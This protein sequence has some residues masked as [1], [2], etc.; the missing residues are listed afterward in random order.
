MASAL[1][2]ANIQTYVKCVTTT[3]NRSQKTSSILRSCSDSLL[4]LSYLECFSLFSRLKI[5]DQNFHAGMGWEKAQACK[6]PN[7]QQRQVIGKTKYRIVFAVC[8]LELYKI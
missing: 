5:K 4:T 1:Q 3:V 2:H 7:H 6:S 8:M